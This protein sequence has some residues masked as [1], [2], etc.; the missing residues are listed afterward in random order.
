M[1]NQL[2]FFETLAWAIQNMCKYWSGNARL[3]KCVDLEG[4]SYG[5]K[6]YMSIGAFSILSICINGKIGQK[7]YPF[8]PFSET[9]KLPI[10]QRTY[11]SSLSLS[12]KVW[13]TVHAI[14]KRKVPNQL[15]L[16]LILERSQTNTP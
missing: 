6:F 8:Y 4:R 3:S 7:V 10:K 13:E 11:L 9:E 2:L 12:G 5:R 14:Q 16:Y 1:R 15:E